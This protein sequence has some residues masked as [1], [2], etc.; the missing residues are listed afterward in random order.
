MKIYSDIVLDYIAGK[1]IGSYK[2][3]CFFKKQGYMF[4]EPSYEREHREA[5]K[6][7]YY[8]INDTISDFTPCNSNIW[9]VLFPTWKLTLENV[10]VN[11]IIGYPEPNDATVLKDPDG[12]N[13]VILDLGLWTKYEGKCEIASVVHNLL[14][15]ELCHV[16]IGATVKDI[17]NDT[18]SSN[19]I[20]NLDANTFHE[21]FAHLISFDDKEID[22][23]NWG[24][25]KLQIV[26]DKSRERMQS[27]LGATDITEQKNNLFE[28][29]YGNYYDKYPCM[30][31]MFYLVDCWKSKG[32]LGL[33]EEFQN[34][35]H[36]FSRKTL[37]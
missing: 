14:T 18:E 10:T 28:A 13:N 2:E 26:K 7:I 3:Q 1:A 4:V 19:Y 11:L 30:C 8:I 17:D 37:G 25:E 12:Q 34:V 21:G 5:V 35:F 27:A 16:L 6:R 22:D 24:L 32:V 20:T 9:D 23:V 36:G 29:V 15:H 31:G 33:K